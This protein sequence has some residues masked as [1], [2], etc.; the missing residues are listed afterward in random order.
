MTTFDH[1]VHVVSINPAA[2]TRSTPSGTGA[3]RPAGTATSSAYPP[4]DEEGADLVADR[5]R[6]HAVTQSRHLARALQPEDVGRAGWRLV[7]ALPL[8]QVGPVHPCGLDADEHFTR[9][10]LGVGHAPRPPGRR[11]HRVH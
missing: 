2:S 9:A 7:E 4:P 8:E 3:T 1:T 5:E 6:R 10:G 11:L